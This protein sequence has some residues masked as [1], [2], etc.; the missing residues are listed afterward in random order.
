MGDI[1]L[2]VLPFF[3]TMLL[4]FSFF[5]LQ[6]CLQHE[7]KNVKGEYVISVVLMIIAIGMWVK[8]SNLI[9]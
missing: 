9:S 2:Y 1:L 3:G 7:Y 8:F 5:L 4:L 6:V